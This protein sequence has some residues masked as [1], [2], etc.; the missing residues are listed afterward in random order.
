MKEEKAIG[1]T[2]IADERKAFEEWFAAHLMPLE[3]DW[4]TRDPLYQSDYKHS[5]VSH[6]WLGWSAR[7][8][9]LKDD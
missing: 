1:Q 3:A 2:T 7:A 6:A 9:T 4:F 5:A 8:G